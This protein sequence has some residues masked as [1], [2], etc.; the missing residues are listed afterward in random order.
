LKKAGL[1]RAVVRITPAKSTNSS[2][3]Q[4]M[5]FASAFALTRFGGLPAERAQRAEMVPSIILA[6]GRC[7]G[8]HSAD[9]QT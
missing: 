5:G 4:A 6:L 7:D 1:V 2:L 9:S 8:R 3:L